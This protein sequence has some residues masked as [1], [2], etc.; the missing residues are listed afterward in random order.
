MS[1]RFATT[2][3]DAKEIGG[4]IHP[5]NI[6]M[7]TLTCQLCSRI[8]TDINDE[9]KLVL[10]KLWS[11]I[12]AEESITEQELTDIAKQIGKPLNV[13]KRAINHTM[14]KDWEPIKH[15]FEQVENILIAVGEAEG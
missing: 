8:N 6:T 15:E 11:R 13:I 1:E 5:I 9:Q 7:K 3:P 14:Q 4:P 2:Y 10:E 12:K